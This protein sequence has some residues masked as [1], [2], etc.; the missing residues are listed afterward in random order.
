MSEAAAVSQNAATKKAPLDEVMLAM[1]VVDTLRHRER[2]V[3]RALSEE[4]QDQQLVARLRDIY[5]GQGI[6]VSD[7]VLERG[8]R[9]LRENRFVYT[10][11]EPSFSRTLANIYVRRDRWG[12]PVMALIGV[13]A[14]G[15]IGYQLLVRAPALRANA[16]LPAELEQA[17]TA[18]V[19]TAID[20]AVD[21]Q[22]EV[23][24][25]DAQSAL[26]RGEY[27]EARTAVTEL[28]ELQATL[29]RQYELRVRSEPGELSGV[30]RIPDAN[31]NAQNYYLIV[32]AIDPD[33]NRLTLPITSEEDGR[34]RRVSA[35]GQRVEAA[36][37]EAIA[38]DK[39]DDGIIQNAVIG[40]KARGELEPDY[41]SGVLAGAITDW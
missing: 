1:D 28:D 21:A 12:I 6:E 7:A 3:E 4:D 2:V 25:G 31:A 20:P 9:D 33:G 30:W 16:A 11:T 41:R 23:I 39:Q 15:L 37:F 8:V 26:E 32:E 14:A 17:Y 19:E 36:T 35:W 10:P 29:T 27:D 13:V 38:A 5:A 24:R 22:A 40:E 34:T 18:V